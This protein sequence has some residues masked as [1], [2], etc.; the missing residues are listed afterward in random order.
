MAIIVFGL[1]IIIH[2]Y[3]ALCYISERGGAKAC[4]TTVTIRNFRHKPGTWTLQHGALHAIMYVIG[5]EVEQKC[6]VLW[7]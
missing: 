3:K 1:H 5:E 6:T 2:N 4:P 7:L